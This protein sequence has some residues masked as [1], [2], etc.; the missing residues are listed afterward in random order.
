MGWFVIIL[1]AIAGISLLG[2]HISTNGPT[3]S[4]QA[5]VA[6]RRVD[7]GRVSGGKYSGGA[8]NYL[9]TFTLSDGEAIELYVT[10][11]QYAELKEGTKG[12]LRWQKDTMLGFD[13]EQTE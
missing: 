13:P 2:Y 7:L 8:W 12:F 1:L 10:K 6:S 5:Q 11:G 4:G 9:V 3:L